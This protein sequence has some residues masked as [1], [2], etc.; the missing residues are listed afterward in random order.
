MAYTDHAPSPEIF[1]LWSGISALAGAC[2]RRYWIESAQR[3]IFPNMFVLLVAPPGVG[4]D[5]AI[6]ATQD[7]WYAVRELKIA[8][9]SITA[10]AMLDKFTD[11]RRIYLVNGVPTPEFEYHSMQ[12]LAPELGIFLNAYDLEFISRLNAIFDNP[13][14]LR[15]MRK[16]MKEEVQIY[17]PQLNIL[18][19]T[20]PGFL[21]SVMPEQAW[22]MGFTSRL[23]MVYANLGPKVDLFAPVPPSK[24]DTRSALVDR[25][26]ELATTHGQFILD[27]EAMDAI[28]EW[29]LQGCPPVP[30]HLK[31]SHYCARRIVHMFK[32][33]MI[34]CLSRGE[35]GRAG[36]G[37]RM[38]LEDVERAKRW[39]LDAE[40]LMPDIFRDMTYKSDVEI[41][42]DLHYYL[43]KLFMEGG[44]SPVHQSY[45]WEFLQ[46]KA[47]SE[48]I[49]RIIEAA[50][51][52]R[53][54]EKVPGTDT[55]IP[56]AKTGSSFI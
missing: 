23:I 30:S 38:L 27:T 11:S 36:V 51:K 5:Q 3:K 35:T 53:F 21:A 20:Q 32:L 40:R 54:L 31:L 13:P 41:L 46:N 52:S 28:R 49:P 48:R 50:E 1:R 39:L 34:A 43:W 33:A 22:S 26:K 44:K 9:T 8:P 29:Y 14:D 25:L 42:Q 55:Y 24:A 56:K 15:V 12:I 6:T 45:I 17:Q 7:L 2:E 4:K 18:A 47:P 37:P 10:A 19:G 16:Y